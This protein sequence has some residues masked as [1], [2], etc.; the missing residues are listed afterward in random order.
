[1]KRQL[2]LTALA[3]SFTVPVLGQ[4]ATKVFKL[5]LGSPSRYSL[6]S[7]DSSTRLDIRSREPLAFKLINSNPYKY[8]YVINHRLVNL[9]ENSGPNPLDSIGKILSGKAVPIPPADGKAAATNQKI[10]DTNAEIDSV[11][12]EIKELLG[13]KSSD[14]KNKD[15]QNKNLIIDMQIMQKKR[16][17][18]SLIADRDKL[19]KQL[20]AIYPSRSAYSTNFVN[21]VKFNNFLGTTRLG[22]AKKE[23]DDIENIKTAITI[24]SQKFNDLDQDLNKYIGKIAAEDFLQADEFSTKRS[25][26]LTAFASVINS[27]QEIGNEANQFDE[28]KK[29]YAETLKNI[30]PVSDKIKEK[31]NEMQ[32]LKL[33]NYLLPV[34]INGK[35]IDAVE[36][37]VERYA[38]NKATP[39]LDKY[40]YNIWVKGGVKIDVSAGVFISSLMD[41]E[42]EIRG[43]GANQTIWDKKKGDYDFGFGSTV[44]LSLRSADWVRPTLSLGALFTTNQKFQLLT[45]IGVILGKEERIILQGGLSMGRTSSIMGDYKTDGSV[46]Y[47][48][49]T[50]GTVPTND[51]FTFGHFFGISY[52]FGKVN[53]ETPAK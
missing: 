42:Y 41:K 45:G 24:L 11:N 50:S 38:R 20:E 22:T 48:L 10:K 39:S 2:L 18:D 43:T 5:D 33:H 19:K 12:N 49:G 47:D 44:N 6:T 25:D 16:Q 27:S 40:T 31:V 34:D 37:T 4:V 30:Q 35:N 28:T 36:V 26:F 29:I 52:N 23:S 7:S 46:G 51:K 1:M 9:F 3:L 53:K 21:T 8:T 17:I 13:Q 14:T 15:A 32:Q